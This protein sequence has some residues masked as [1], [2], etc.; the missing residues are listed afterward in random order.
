[1]VVL[2]TRRGQ[3]SSFVRVR[4]EV[5]QV[6]V[7]TAVSSRTHG[8]TAGHNPVFCDRYPTRTCVAGNGGVRS[9]GDKC[10]LHPYRDGNETTR[11]RCDCQHQG[12]R[13]LGLR[14]MVNICEPLI[15]VVNENKPKVLACP[16][17]A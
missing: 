15:N 4:H 10:I 16:T 12:G 3:V 5:V 17:K 13:G 8:D 7:V 11:G 2:Q 1:V 9:S 6:A 14:S